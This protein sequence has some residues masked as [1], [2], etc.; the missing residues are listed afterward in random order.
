MG[1]LLLEISTGKQ[2]AKTE[3]PINSQQFEEIISVRGQEMFA[4]A[5]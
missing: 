1:Y 4:T 5:I 2:N 3:A